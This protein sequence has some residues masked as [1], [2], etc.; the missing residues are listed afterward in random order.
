MLVCDLLKNRFHIWD[1]LRV[2]PV[3]FN[4]Y[5]QPML[6]REFSTFVERLSNLS[7]RFFFRNFRWQ[8]IW[9]HFYTRSSDILTQYNILFGLI[10]VFSDLLW[11][12]TMILEV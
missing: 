10:N 5:N 8:I 6:T 4:P 11:I 12:G 7:N 3:I 9:F 2:L 1:L